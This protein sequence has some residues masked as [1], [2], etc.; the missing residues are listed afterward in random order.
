[1]RRI[2]VFGIAVGMMMAMA[3]PALADKPA[4]SAFTDTFTDIDA[5]TGEPMLITINYSVSEHV[6][7]NNVV[8]HFRATGETDAGYTMTNGVQHI[9]ESEQVFTLQFNDIWHN[10]DGRKMKASGVLV[11][12][13]NRGELQVEKFPPDT[14]RCLGGETILP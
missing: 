5:C 12:N 4:E 14:L 6:H 1:M 3:V 13:F 8:A 9:V 10:P 2:L 7:G 11:F